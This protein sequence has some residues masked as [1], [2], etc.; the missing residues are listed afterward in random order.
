MTMRLRLAW[1]MVLAF[2]LTL[3][4]LSAF[5]AAEP[6]SGFDTGTIP[7]PHILLPDGA[8]AAAVV[9]I[10]DAKGWGKVEDS[11]AQRL[12]ATGAAVIGIDFPSY[13][14]ELR[15]VEGDCV[16]TVSD[17]ESLSQQIQRKAGNTD[18]KLPIVAGIGEGAALALAIAA[19]SPAATFSGTIA[20]DPLAGI[21]LM[22]Q[23]CTPAQKQI[24][25]DRMIYAMTEGPLPDP[26]TLVLSPNADAAGRDHV[27][28]LQTAHPDIAVNESDN[29]ANS[30]LSE[31]LDNAIA[32]GKASES[33]L[34]LPI[35]I[36]PAKPALKTM[37]IIYSGDGGWRDLDKEIGISLQSKGIPIIGVDSLRYFWSKRT[38]E[39]TAADLAK[40]I[41][42][43]RKSWNVDH[44]LLIGYSFGADIL[45]ATYNLLSDA[46]KERVPQISLLALSHQVDY[47]IS[48]MGWLGQSASSGSGDPVDDLT[49]IDPKKI[50]CVYGT[51]ED[52]DACTAIKTAGAEIIPIDGGH[53]FDGD[54]PA[55][56]AKIIAG[57]ERRLQ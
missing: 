40:M 28:T 39:E 1:T 17:L 11:E 30:A 49:K 37:A 43:Y 14:A 33:P 35:E 5:A 46:D 13:I 9:L 16:Y 15:K 19:Q 48:V 44:I 52:Q 47:E 54:Y 56:A 6:A 25:A 27:M 32:A 45:P 34:G 3:S 53:H 26:V 20:V 55:L 22:K 57:L 8:I 10:S 38:P 50:Q 4:G 24:A 42:F 31:M 12:A 23:L 7:A 51:E 18:Y 2:A 36:L 41:V 21:P 29:D